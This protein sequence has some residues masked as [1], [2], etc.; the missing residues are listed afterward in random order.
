[1][2]AFMDRT[3]IARMLLAKDIVIVLIRSLTAHFQG[4]LA[5]I[6]APFAGTR[7]EAV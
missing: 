3:R 2:Q 6:T 7:T 1:M 5:I 4:S